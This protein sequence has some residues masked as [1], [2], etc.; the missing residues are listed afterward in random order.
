[1]KYDDLVQRSSAVSRYYDFHKA[2]FRNFGGFLQACLL[3]P[4]GGSPL[5]WPYGVPYT[6][7]QAAILYPFGH[8]TSMS[9]HFILIHY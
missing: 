5:K 6:V 7:Q 1:M 2:Q 9:F 4:A 3:H 8:P